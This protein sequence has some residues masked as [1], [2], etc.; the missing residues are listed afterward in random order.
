MMTHDSQENIRS[1]SNFFDN[2]G[3]RWISVYTRGGAERWYEYYP[4]RIRERY[5]LSLIGNEPRGTAVDLGCGAGH[6]LLGMKRMGFRRIIGV[7][8]SDNMLQSA[9]KMIAGNGPDG[10]IELYKCDV[11]NLQVIES[12][13][14]DVCTALGLIE[15][16]STDELLLHEAHRILKRNGALVIQ[17]KNPVCYKNVAVNGLRTLIPAL[18]DKILSRQHVPRAF[19]ETLGHS[20]FAVEEFRFAH[21]YA[22]FPLTYTPGVRLLIGWLDGWLSGHMELLSRRWIS[23]YLASM[24]IVKARKAS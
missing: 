18:K 10:T 19:L 6:A 11:Q 24:F 20:G 22:L 9:R 15:Y 23:R 7:D 5:A 16:L 3:D 13:S 4:L 21:Y 1:I 12:G 17:V 8:I 2:F 14:A